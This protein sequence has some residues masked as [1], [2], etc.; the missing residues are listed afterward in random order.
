MIRYGLGDSSVVLSLTVRDG[1]AV[2]GTTLKNF[3]VLP[4]WIFPLASGKVDGADRFYKQGLGFSGPSAFM[5]IPGPEEL[6]WDSRSVSRDVWSYDSYL[7]TGFMSRAGRTL[8]VSARD[9]RRY[10]QRSCVYNRMQRFGLTDRKVSLYDVFFE[11]G[12][13]TERTRPGRGDVVLPDFYFSAGDR[14]DEVFRRTAREIAEANGV[15]SVKPPRYHFCSWYEYEKNYD[16]PKLDDLLDGLKGIKPAIPLQTIQI[17][18][19]CVYGDWLLPNERWPGTIK[20][21]FGKIRR[22]GYAAGIWI[23]PFMVS[24]RSAVFREHPDWLLRNPEGGLIVE[25]KKPEEDIHVLDTSH[26]AAFEWLRGVF[27]TLREWGAS[28][29]K[30][31]FMDWGLKDSTTV[32]RHRPGKTSAQYFD[33]VL[34]M[35]REEIGSESFWLGC[36]APYQSMIGYADAVRI[37]NDILPE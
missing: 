28:Y 25:W 13:G 3:L 10:V 5:E 6:R 34:K 15:D 26:P 29:F 14:A 2:L 20:E 18:D 31:D 30:T 22:N 24:S 21:A 17:D 37:T 1:C 11:A 8:V 27:R 32:T 23:G 4:G 12:F 16:I 36:I 33:E 7:V 19:Y 9:S 35:I